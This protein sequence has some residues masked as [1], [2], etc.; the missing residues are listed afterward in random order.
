MKS[1]REI[2]T[3]R[4]AYAHSMANEIADYVRRRGHFV[5][6]GRLARLE[7]FNLSAKPR[8][9]RQFELDLSQELLELSKLY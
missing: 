9:I 4:A 1:G 7:A 3:L 6:P 5:P 8:P 2:L